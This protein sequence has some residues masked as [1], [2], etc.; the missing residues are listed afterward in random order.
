M[1]PGSQERYA[2]IKLASV[3]L[4]FPELGRILGQHFPR[5]GLVCTVLGLFGMATAVLAATARIWQLTF[6]RA[7]VNESVWDL[8]AATP[9]LMPVGLLA[10]LGPL[11]AVFLGIGLLRVPAFP[12]WSAALLIVG[13]ISF[14]I[15]Q[16]AAVAITFLCPLATIAWFVALAPLG[17]RIWTGRVSEIVGETAVA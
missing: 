14:V 16:G 12:H 3:L 8:L 6:L 13:G 5:Y 4:V 2:V 15:S 1:T 10:P 11:T 7:G 9:E 17:W